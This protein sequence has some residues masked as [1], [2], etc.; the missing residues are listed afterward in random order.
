MDLFNYMEKIRTCNNCKHYGHGFE[1]GFFCRKA[2]I[3]C[4]RAGVGKTV[5]LV[6][7]QETQTY[8]YF[9]QTER[10]NTSTQF[11]CGKDGRFFEEKI[12]DF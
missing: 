3:P 1:G 7:G 12:L 6:N 11:C 2:D 5:D 8:T 4:L 10:Q 9:C